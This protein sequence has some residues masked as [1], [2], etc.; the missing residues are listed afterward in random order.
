MSL[1]SGNNCFVKFDDSPSP[2]RTRHKIMFSG[3]PEMKQK[4][5]IKEG[6]NPNKWEFLELS[7]S[8]KNLRS[9]IRLCLL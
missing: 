2:S 8:L 5:N 6:L 9:P 1:N 4:L 7:G 3:R